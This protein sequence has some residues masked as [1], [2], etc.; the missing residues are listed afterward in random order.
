MTSL[1]LAGE[2]PLPPNSGSR[3]RTVHLARALAAALPVE[4][5]VL[6][7]AGDCAGEPYP[8]TGVHHRRSR[9]AGLARSARRPYGA[10]MAA[11]GALTALAR[12]RRPVVAQAQALWVM[13]AAT[14]AGGAVVLDAHNVESDLLRRL[15]ADERR[16]LHRLRWRWEAGKTAAWERRAAVRADAVC[17]TSPDDA[18]AFERWGAREVV[19]VPNGTDTAAVPHGPPPG[20]A[21]LAYVGHYGYQPNAA[22][23][24]E[25]AAEVLPRVRADVPEADAAIVGRDPTPALRGA[26]GPHVRVTGTVPDVLP[27]LRTARA[28]VVPLRS[29]GGTR[30]KVL[31]ALAAGVPVI[32]TPLGVEGLDLRDGEHVLVGRSSADLAALAVRVIRDDALAARLS[33]AGRA[34]V[35]AAYDWAVVARP[36]VDLHLRLHT[37]R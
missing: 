27:H 10:A 14:A 12:A 24:L 1:L 3:Q 11:S 22:A 33:A 25:L 6:G 21:T 23:A 36:L 2:T 19:L 7:P 15:A 26:A 29:G 16:P 13:P 28:L 5:A 4:L 30:L 17:A 8:V 31:E 34:R 32:S 9:L 18:A 20:G 37:A 35:E